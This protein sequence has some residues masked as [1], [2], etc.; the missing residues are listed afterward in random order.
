LDQ[1]QWSNDVDAHGWIVG[2]DYQDD[3]VLTDGVAVFK[4][5]NVFPKPADYGMSWA[6]A[7]SDDGM[8]IVGLNDDKNHDG[9]QRGVIWKCR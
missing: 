7:I 5:K 2:K 6:Q 4:L 8:T 3:A 1:I 9:E